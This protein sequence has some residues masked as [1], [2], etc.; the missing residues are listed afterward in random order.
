VYQKVFITAIL[1][2]RNIGRQAEMVTK[3]ATFPNSVYEVLRLLTNESRMDVSLPLALKDL[4]RLKMKDLDEK[5]AAFEKKYGMPYAE[6]EQACVD[7]RIEDSY[8]YAIEKDDWEW[9]ALLTKRK[10]LEIVAQWLE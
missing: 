1:G 4:L 8:S 10:E 3:S 2:N 9:E 5:I 6:F 7:E